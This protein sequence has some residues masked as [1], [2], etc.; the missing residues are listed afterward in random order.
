MQLQRGRRLRRPLAGLELR[1]PE[2]GTLLVSTDLHGNG[3]DF[4][5]LRD[6]FRSAQEGPNP[7]HWVIL[8]DAVHAPS[9]EAE[10]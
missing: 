2:Q 1:L 7:A 10:S 5:R 3:A 9:A 4:R 6:L 8:G